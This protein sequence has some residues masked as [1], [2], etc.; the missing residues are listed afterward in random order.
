LR[1]AQLRLMNDQRF[2]H[3]AYWSPFLLIGDW[4]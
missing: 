2:G 3:P 4:R 1:G